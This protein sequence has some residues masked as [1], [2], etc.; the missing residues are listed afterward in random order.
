[1]FQPY[2]SRH[3]S[4]RDHRKAAREPTLNNRVLLDFLSYSLPSSHHK[5]DGFAFRTRWPFQI[6]VQPV[7]TLSSAELGGGKANCLGKLPWPEA[8]SCHCDI[9]YLPVGSPTRGLV[10][11]LPGNVLWSLIVDTEFRKVLPRLCADLPRR[12]PSFGSDFLLGEFICDLAI[13]VNSPCWTVG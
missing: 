8:D 4:L 2:P 12:D 1:M 9:L 11:Y 6:G 10:C 5:A 7:S 13:L 3:E